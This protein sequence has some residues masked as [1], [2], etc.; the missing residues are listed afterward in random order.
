MRER[1]TVREGGERERE[2]DRQTDKQTDRKKETETER[3]L[4]VLVHYCAL[5]DC[6]SFMHVGF[7]FFACLLFICGTHVFF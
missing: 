4:V 5:L 1:E 6:E 3:M 2:T 7:N